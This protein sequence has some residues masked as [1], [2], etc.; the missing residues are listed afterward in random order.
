MFDK[1][2]QRETKIVWNNLQDLMS[3]FISME[4]T[5]IID[6]YVAKSTLITETLLLTSQAFLF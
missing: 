5:F 4:K 6:V 2:S 3:V 1:E